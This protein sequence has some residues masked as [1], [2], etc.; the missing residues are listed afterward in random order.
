MR[1]K[2]L[3]RTGLGLV[4]RIF[5]VVKM[6]QPMAVNRL[7]DGEICLQIYLYFYERFNLFSL[8]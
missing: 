7:T 1:Y 3:S 6:F 2:G 8:V 5:S 4:N